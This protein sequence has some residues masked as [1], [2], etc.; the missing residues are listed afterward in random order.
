MDVD[1]L[2]DIF[3]SQRKTTTEVFYLP[4]STQHGNRGRGETSSRTEDVPANLTNRWK[5]RCK[6]E[7]YAAFL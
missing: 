4:S 7:Q 3:F 1:D 6:N 2:E 5:N